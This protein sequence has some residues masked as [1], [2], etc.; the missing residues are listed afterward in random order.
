M[1][2]KDVSDFLTTIA[3]LLLVIGS[4]TFLAIFIFKPPKRLVNFLV[5]LREVISQIRKLKLGNLE[6]ELEKP[7]RPSTSEHSITTSTVASIQPSTENELRTETNI[8]VEQNQ[9]DSDFSRSYVLLSEGKYKEGMAVMRE[10]T[11]TKESLTEQIEYIALG[12]Y[13]GFIA[14]TS[15]ALDDLR[16]TIEDHPQQP[17]PRLWL[18]M[19]LDS[20]GKKELA[21]SEANQA[22]QIAKKEIDRAK[23]VRFLSRIFVKDEQF[24]NALNIIRKEIFDL[25]DEYSRTILFSELGEIYESQ[26][27]PDHHKALLMYELALLNSPSD[28]SLRFDVAWKYDNHGAPAMALLH[29][30]ELLNRDPKHPSALN[31][32]GY[33]A[34][35]LS[36]KASANNYYRQS[37]N[38]GE[39]LNGNTKDWHRR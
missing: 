2:L 1:S 26:N 34:E 4:L 13:I 36:L 21:I 25:N 7:I 6:A 35:Q 18:G 15:E 19:A 9:E 16:K 28:Q 3:F 20:V 37:E 5:E 38:Y 8:T 11:T 27:P 30:K 31:N 33:A 14:G 17:M 23:I 32:A 10:F 12:Q 24:E 22:Y 39:T 29:Y